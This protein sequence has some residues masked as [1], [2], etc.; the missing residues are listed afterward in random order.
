MHVAERGVDTALGGNRVRPSREELGDARGLEA[1]LGQT[2]GSSETGTA[3]TND[4]GVVLVV[5]NRVVTNEAAT[6]YLFID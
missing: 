1:G 5:N 2:E 6:L 3:S 4:D